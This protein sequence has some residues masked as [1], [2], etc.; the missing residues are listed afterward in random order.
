[1]KKE[2]QELIANFI[3][4]NP[5][6]TYQQLSDYLGISKSYLN[7]LGTRAGVRRRQRLTEE[8]TVERLNS[9]L[10]EKGGK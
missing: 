6:I 9:L 3:Q 2:V 7:R 8:I 4:R 10:A 1:M 5:E